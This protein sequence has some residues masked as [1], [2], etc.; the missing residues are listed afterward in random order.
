[1]IDDKTR[2]VLENAITFIKGM[3]ANMGQFRKGLETS[4]EELKKEG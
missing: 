1:M 2:R 4:L 3:E